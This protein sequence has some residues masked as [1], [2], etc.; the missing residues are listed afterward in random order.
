M[1]WLP[2]PAAFLV[3]ASGLAAGLWIGKREGKRFPVA[4]L[5]ACI[6]LIGLRI[7]WRLYPETE[8]DLFPFDAYVR[9]RPWWAIPFA[10]LA[11][12]VGAMRMSTRGARLGVATAGALLVVMGLQYV[13]LTVRI[14]HSRM[15]GEPNAD[16]I[17]PQTTDYT[18]GAAAAATLV[19]RLGARATEREMA[20]LCG[21]NAFTGTDE[22]GVAAGL[23][24]KLTGT[25]RRVDVVGADWEGLLRA[26]K[27]AAA[28][29][30]YSPTVDHWVVVLDARPDRVLIAD[31]V[32]GREDW[33]RQK[34]ESR[35]RKVLVY[36]A[37]PNE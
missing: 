10:T 24:A 21:T 37:A 28:T 23:R 19:S 9:V 2:L 27:P 17:C 8:Y 7:F 30:R 20:A 29:I 36:A 15:A 33:T 32:R 35:W 3:F 1:H 34:F 25:G 26:P 6:A 11:A 22:F 31:P 16:G 14:D 13:W 18:C 4:A 5:C 12:G